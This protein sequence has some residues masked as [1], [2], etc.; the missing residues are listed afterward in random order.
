MRRTYVLQENGQVTLPA[1]W[2]ERQGLKKGDLVT[3]VET[4]QGLLVQPRTPV[5]MHLLDRIGKILREKGIELEDM[6]EDGRDIRE[7]LYQERYAGK[8]A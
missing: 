1:K 7:E 4:E 2:R 8:G 5:A 6:I 3:F